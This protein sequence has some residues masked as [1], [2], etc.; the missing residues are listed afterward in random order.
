M[1][2]I[3]INEY[4]AVDVET[5][6]LDAAY[7]RI[8]EIGA[9]RYRDG[10]ESAIFQHLI[11]QERQLDANIT[12]LTGI[13]DEMLKQARPEKEVIQEFLEFAADDIILGHNVLFDYSFLKTTAG[14]H[15]YSFECKGFDTLGLAKRFH[16]KE[17][18]RSLE[19]MCN[20]YQIHNERA[21]RALQ[22]ARAAATLFHRFL[23][24]FAEDESAFVPVP[25]IYQE[26]KQ[27]PI[28][29]KQKKYLLDLIKYHRI[30]SCEN[31]DLMT[32]SE[33]SKKIDSIILNYGRMM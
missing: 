32:K 13:T 21:H 22:D 15:G 30:E 8:I 33:A 26:K 10:K 17:G 31:L 24:S 29:S 2:S 18:S 14:R 11:Y 1:H 23:D 6:G 3:K 16:K 20:Y 12:R 28:T 19:A 9:I 27:S 4:I 25:L 5:T 7:E